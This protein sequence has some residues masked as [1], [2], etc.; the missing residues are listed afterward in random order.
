MLC[1]RVNFL[2]SFMT[3]CF[4]YQ[5]SKHGLQFAPGRVRF[6]PAVA[7]SIHTSTKHASRPSGVISDASCPPPRIRTEGGLGA[8]TR[9][10][11]KHPATSP[12]TSGSVHS[13][14]KHAAIATS[15]T[16]SAANESRASPPPVRKYVNRPPGHRRFAN[17]SSDHVRS[18]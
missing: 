6:A 3:R 15:R 10:L 17:K 8:L 11:C 16:R 13:Y 18:S 14:H 12:H 2:E 1:K 4:L 5:G 9:S 7:H